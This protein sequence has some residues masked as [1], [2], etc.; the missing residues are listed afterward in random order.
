MSDD[1][2]DQPI[3]LLISTIGRQDPGTKHGPTGP[4]R[5]TLEL[6]PRRVLLLSNPGVA[7]NAEL[8]VSELRDLAPETE[9][10]VHELQVRDMSDMDE[11]FS[12]LRG[13]FAD[14]TPEGA[15]EVAICAT[16]GTPQLFAAVTLAAETSLV[17][18]R[19]LQALNPEH[20][21]TVL[22]E[23]HP[24][25]MRHHA[26]AQAGFA[27]LATCDTDRAA[28]LL[29]RRRSSE[30][31][32]AVRSRPAF[33]AGENV[34]AALSA[35][36]DFDAEKAHRRATNWTPKGLEPA[37][38]TSLE[39]LRD[40]YASIKASPAKELKWPVELAARSLR[41]Q[42]AGAL[43][44]AIIDAATA[45][46][47]AFARRLR[48]E[49]DVDPAKV[50]LRQFALFADEDPKQQIVAVSSS[51]EYGY[52]E[53]SSKLSR[54]LRRCEPAFDELM[55]KHEPVRK[56]L[57]DARNDLAHGSL[58]PDMEAVGALL[59]QFHAFLDALFD[60]FGWP[61]P[62]ECPTSPTAI[63]ALATTLAASAGV[64]IR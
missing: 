4:L 38:V 31:S 44:A 41:Q 26:E 34:A 58:R 37:A 12:A 59:P 61:V 51:G 52:I 1:E 17:A 8:T 13:V 40:W 19:H 50:K 63:H 53:G 64:T 3:Y 56:S 45:A 30:I 25:L 23:F 22:R 28:D 15:G 54:A 7:E 29:G 10:T 42:T 11:I 9:V 36:R 55:Q 35:I 43:A 5:A 14:I 24:D 60:S 39:R 21:T 16:S 32:V 47:V 6:R 62:S 57:A 48:I 49:H 33:R 20:A 18:P 46:E 27:A 2:R